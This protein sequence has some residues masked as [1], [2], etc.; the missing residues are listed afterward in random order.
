MSNTLNIDKKRW[1]SLLLQIL[2]GTASS[3]VYVLSIFIGPLIELRGWD[4]N[5]ILFAFTLAMW[6]G[7]PSIIIGGKICEKLGPKKTISFAGI[8]YGGAIVAS[9]FVTSVVAFLALQGVIASF[10]MFV[11]SVCCLENIGTLYPDKRGWATGLVL[12]GMGIGGAVIAPIAQYIT[13]HASVVV[14][15]AGQGI[16]YALIMAIGGALIIEAPKGYKPAGWEPQSIEEEKASGNAMS[17][18]TG[19]DVGWTKMIRTPAFWCIFIA[20]LLINIVGCIPIANAAFMTEVA[21]GVSGATAAWVLSAVTIGCAVGNWAGGWIADKIGAMKTLAIIGLFNCIFIVI[22]AT[23][24]M[25][26]LPV[27]GVVLTLIAV[28]YGGLT[29]IMPVLAMNTFGEKNFGVNYGIIGCNAI[30]VNAISPQ[31]T[32][33]DNLAMGFFISGALALVGA[34]ISVIGIKVISGYVN[35]SWKRLGKDTATL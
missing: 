13:D 5:S 25:G 3:F 34:I 1:R 23:V 6:V 14:S 27:W 30:V 32:L 20:L 28:D 8:F 15:I 24:G 16:V 22:E 17:N 7:S 33:M 10:F 11:I 29:T 4:A 31:L 35:K 18:V 9:A 19:P 12:A 2:I 26:S 21:L